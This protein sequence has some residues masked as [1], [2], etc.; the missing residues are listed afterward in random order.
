VSIPVGRRTA[1]A[2]PPAA[3]RTL[4]GVDYVSVAAPDGGMDIAVILGEI[5]IDRG[6]TRVE[7][8]SGLAEGDRVVLP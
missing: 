5:F 8:L 1:L 3:V 6:A 4:H 7:V 2:V